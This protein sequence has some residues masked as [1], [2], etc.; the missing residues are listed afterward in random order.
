MIPNSPQRL[1]SFIAEERHGTMA[2]MAE[3]EDRRAKLRWRCGR[4]RNPQSFW[5]MNY[6]PDMD[7][8]QRLEEQAVGRH[9]RLCAEP[10][11]P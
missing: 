2:W 5:R 8:L 9:L 11:L 4:K 3:T 10:R 6:T 7:P 1:R